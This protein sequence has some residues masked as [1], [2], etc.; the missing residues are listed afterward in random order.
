MSEQPIAERAAAIRSVLWKVFA[1]NL[2]VALSKL[3]YGLVLGAVSMTADGLHSLLDSFSNIIGLIGM[4]AA[5]RPADPSH[6]YGHRKFE[7]LA[8]LGICLLLFLSSYEVVKSAIGRLLHPAPLDPPA[9]SLGLML[10][11]MGVNYLISRYELRQGRA[12]RSYILIADS[13]HTFSD[14]FASGAVLLALLSARAGYPSVDALGSFLIVG[15]IGWV[16]YRILKLNVDAL[17]DA[18]QVPAKMVEQI[19]LALPEVRECHGVRSRGFPDAIALDLHVLVDPALPVVEAHRVADVVEQR[20]LEQIPGVVDV[21]VHV[22]PDTP[23]ERQRAEEWDKLPP[24][25]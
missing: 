1:L 5:A 2:A 10:G 25:G 4:A 20:I 7:A 11:N 3:T 15:L 23:E 16:A 12:L 14:I 24:L 22:E 9:W 17:A 8:A 21:V 13:A 6:P 19:V 18:S